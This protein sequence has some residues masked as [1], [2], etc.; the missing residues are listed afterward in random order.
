[1]KPIP[2]KIQKIKNK[3]NEIVTNF[4]NNIAML[5]A[6]TDCNIHYFPYL[7]II[8]KDH[9]QYVFHSEKN[10]LPDDNN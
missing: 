1:M 5:E 7:S 6:E 2:K 3:L 10:R 4:N 9:K 8:I